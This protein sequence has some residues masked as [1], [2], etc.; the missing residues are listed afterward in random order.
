MDGRGGCRRLEVRGA[1][2]VVGVLGDLEG[3][4]VVGGRGGCRRLEVRG[5]RNEPCRGGLGG[6]GGVCCGRG[7]V[8]VGG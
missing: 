8:V 7:Q 2:H 1:S 3:C 5:Q 6:L 4:V